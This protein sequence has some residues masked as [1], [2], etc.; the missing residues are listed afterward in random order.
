MAVGD[1]SIVG[2]DIE[3]CEGAKLGSNVTLLSQG[4]IGFDAVIEDHVRI[5]STRS[6][7]AQISNGARIGARCNLEGAEHLR[8][9][10]DATLKQGGIAMGPVQIGEDAVVDEQVFIRNAKVG[11]QRHVP[12]GVRINGYC[13]EQIDH[14]DNEAAGRID[15]S[16][17]GTN[18]SC[19]AWTDRA[20][21]PRPS[22][23][24][25]SSWRTRPKTGESSFTR[26]RAGWT[27]RS[28][29]GAT[30]GGE[31]TMQAAH[32]AARAACCRRE[33]RRA[34]TE[35]LASTVGAT[36]I[37]HRMAAKVGRE[38][39]GPEQPWTLKAAGALL[40]KEPEVLEQIIEKWRRVE[41]RMTPGNPD[42]TLLDIKERL[43]NH[44][45]AKLLDDRENGD[46]KGAREL[47]QLI[48]ALEPEPLQAEENQLRNKHYQQHIQ[49]RVARAEREGS[50]PEQGPVKPPSAHEH[51][52]A[53]PATHT[54]K[55][56]PTE[57]G[58]QR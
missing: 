25:A 22:G 37:A 28:A 45:A 34:S 51:V 35:E 56:D 41:A 14:G 33:T 49:G 30:R 1:D 55:A 3:L 9:K 16:S 46:R 4:R 5:G 7:S 15:P 44:V 26:G 57:R 2:A 40:Q 53:R 29:P 20:P 54:P 24:A 27:S 8:I 11:T 43:E 38:W 47:D 12:A 39:G 23:G 6:D 32:Y 18:R 42:W 10:R 50:H 48:A 17:T 36:L 31:I 21:S 58:L 52:P 13:P 19:C